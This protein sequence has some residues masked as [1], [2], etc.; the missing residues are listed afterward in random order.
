MKSLYIEPIQQ[1]HGTKY[2]TH[3]KWSNNERTN[4]I[5]VRRDKDGMEQTKRIVRHLRVIIISIGHGLFTYANANR[6]L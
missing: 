5:D 6:M 2:H 1:S 4:G 3:S